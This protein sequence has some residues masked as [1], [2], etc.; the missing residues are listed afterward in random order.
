[1]FSQIS[2]A[3][4]AF[5]EPRYVATFMAILEMLK[6][7][8]ISVIEDVDSVQ[9]DGVVNLSDNVYIRLYTGKIRNS[10]ED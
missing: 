4:I 8:R 7:G 9:L 10:Q 5:P 1:M 3:S 6:A 2:P